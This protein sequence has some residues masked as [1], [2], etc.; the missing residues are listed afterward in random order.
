MADSKLKDLIVGLLTGD[1]PN[2]ARAACRLAAEL[3]LKETVPELMKALETKFWQ[4]RVEAV[5]ALGVLGQGSPPVER[6]MLKLLGAGDQNAR[7][8]ILIAASTEGRAVESTPDLAGQKKD[9]QPP[10]V[11]RAAALAL[12][13]LRP[14]IAETVLVD[15]LSGENP[16]LV[17]AAMSGLASLESMAGAD[18]MTD[19]LGHPDAK[20]R[21]AAVT[22]LGRLK[23]RAAAPRLLELLDDPKAEIRQEAVIALN[24]LKLPEAIDHLIG[25]LADDS[26]DVRRVAAVA[27]GNTRSRSEDV[28]RALEV[29]LADQHWPVRQAAVSSLANLRAEG[30]LD[31]LIAALS[32][33]RDEVRRE[34]SLACFKLYVSL[35]QPDY[36]RAPP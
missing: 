20:T 17:Q 32:D 18:K 2:L 5:R 29:A 35:D 19:L 6:A 33:P 14:D 27:L 23:V 24:H 30:S 21:K 9:S 10:Q 36:E 25:K 13:R 11:Q 22:G 12:S 28:I 4:I 3:D 26:A 7:Q 8:R 34:A 16:G 15:T 1:D 31:K